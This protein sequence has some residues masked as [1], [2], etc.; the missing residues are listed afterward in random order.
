MLRPQH[1]IPDEFQALLPVAS[2]IAR[3]TRFQQLIQFPVFSGTAS[4]QGHIPKAEKVLFMHTGE[5]I[6]MNICKVV[7]CVAVHLG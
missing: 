6:N 1:I 4:L 5:L 7:A 3:I 2:L